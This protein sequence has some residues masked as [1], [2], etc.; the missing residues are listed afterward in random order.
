MERMR[1]RASI[2]R[3]AY[4]VLLVVGIIGSIILGIEAKRS[5]NFQT[6]ILFQSSSKD[7][8]ARGVTFFFAGLIVTLITTMPLL[9]ISWIIDGQADLLAARSG[10]SA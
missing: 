9:G 10:E 8:T 6:A 2:M 4:V 7:D 5:I 1:A 3:T